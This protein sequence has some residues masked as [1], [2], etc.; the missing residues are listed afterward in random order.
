MSAGRWG[1]RSN[2]QD[3][4]PSITLPGGNEARMGNVPALGEHTGALP[5]AVGMTDDD[6]AV[7]HRNGATA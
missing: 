3:T 7:R 6:I 2:A 4:L 1:G 5:R